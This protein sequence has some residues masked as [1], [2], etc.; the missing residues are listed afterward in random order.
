MIA[1]L[2]KRTDMKL[3]RCFMM[4]PLEIAR[5]R[6]ELGIPSL[7]DR[8]RRTWTAE[9][10]A[11]LGTMSDLEVA[12]RLGVSPDQA[13]RMRVK[14]GR[15]VYCKVHWTPAAIAMLGTMKDAEAAARLGVSI[16][17][18]RLKRTKLGIQQ[19]RPKRP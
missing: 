1:L 13:R 17:Y 4:P 18:V 8:Q 14:Q 6:K 7:R 2:G 19:F 12:R 11:L 3:A 10:I 5:K 15:A 9:E 16:H